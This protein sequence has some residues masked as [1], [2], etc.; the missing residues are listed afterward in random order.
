M[1]RKTRAT[2][3]YS[4]LLLDFVNSLT[5]IQILM[6]YVSDAGSASVF[7]QGAHKMLDPLNQAILS[8]CVQ[9]DRRF[10]TEGGTEHTSEAKGTP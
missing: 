5:Y 1:I 9:N 6:Q 7:R 10:L 3:R 8:H 4:I 2:Y